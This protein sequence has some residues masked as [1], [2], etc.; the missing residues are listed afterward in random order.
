MQWQQRVSSKWSFI[1]NSY[2][3]NANGHY[4]YKVNGDGSDT[5]AT[6]TNSGLNV[7]SADGALYWSKNDSNKFNLHL[8][9]YNSNRGLPGAV[10]FYNPTS[11]QH[12]WNKD[13]FVQ[14]GY[15]R[16]WK[17]SFHLLI[18]IKLS[19]NYTRYVDPDYLNNQGGLD[20]R[21]TQREFYQ[22]AALSYHLLSNWEMSYAADASISDLN[23]N[24]PDYSYPT[25]FSLLNVLAT[26]LILGRWH[27]QGNL[28]N[29]YINERVKIG[30]ASPASNVVSPTVMVVYQPKNNS[31]LQFR[32]FYK[33]IFRYPT[34]NDLYF[35]PVN[36]PRNLKPEYAKQF[37]AGI[38]Y[39]KGINSILD[40]ITFSL[41]GYYNNL[42]NKIIYLPGSNIAMSSIINLGKVVIKGIDVGIKTQTVLINGWQGSIVINYTFQDAIDV[43]DPISSVYRQQIPYTPKNTIALNGGADYKNIGLYYNQVLSSDRYYLGENLPANL[44]YGYSVSDLS[45][46]YKFLT[47]NKPVVLSAHIDNV[48]NENYLIVR[49]FPMP[50]RSFLLSF[51]ITI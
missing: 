11:N 38:T 8:S 43:T 7:Q 31:N 13:F 6:R 42:T 39:R 10:V 5:S 35:F 36:G 17:S 29:T 47:G 27:F 30:T 3:E 19:Q 20:E 46:I 49:S 2:L 33:D 34:F 48:F 9:Y 1:I 44:V 28:L 37:D 15:E 4:K 18:N 40:F 14:S 16:L 51:Q 21:Y 24:L 45:F 23:A 41:D 12:L 32:A 26:K 50:G 22:S 25:R